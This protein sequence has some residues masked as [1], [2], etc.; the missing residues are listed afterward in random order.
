MK[1]DCIRYVMNQSGDVILSTR[2]WT[3]HSSPFTFLYA[4]RLVKRGDDTVRITTKKTQGPASAIRR[5]KW[6]KFGAAVNDKPLAPETNL[7]REINFEFTQPE[8]TEWIPN[9]MYVTRAQNDGWSRDDIKK[10]IRSDR[11]DLVYRQIWNTKLRALIAET[12]HKNPA[13]VDEGQSQVSTGDPV[14][15][16]ST[17]GMGIRERLALKKKG[18]SSASGTAAKGGI[19]AR[20]N[21]RRNDSGR[22]ANRDESKCT[23]FV[24]NVPDDYDEHAIRQEIAD[25]QY[26][27]VNIVRRDGESVG[28]AFIELD[29]E[30]D[31]KI[32]QE[33]INGTRWGHCIISAQFARPKRK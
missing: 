9:G 12:K 28:K 31:A 1:N 7:G 27:R 6:K 5:L 22:G 29:T 18:R 30:E 2:N 20:M 3:E 17:K 21:Q 19:S 11:P 16:V 32:C 33:V 4:E 10:I 14:E 8:A 15:P 24:E 13:P 23:L 26:R 25:H